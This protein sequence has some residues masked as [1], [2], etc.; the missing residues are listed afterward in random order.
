[1]FDDALVESRKTHSL[2]GTRRSLPASVAL[3][4]AV[5]GAFVGASA[6]FPGE[7]PEPTER[8]VLPVVILP[9]PASSSRDTGGG[10]K[11]ET[12]HGPGPRR[13][14]EITQQDLSN[15]EPVATTASASPSDETPT[16]DVTENG[17]PGSGT[18]DEVGEHGGGGK[19]G[20]GGNGEDILT[21]G[22]D[23]RA[24]VLLDRVEPAYPESARRAHLE[25]IVILEA[26]ITAS[27]EVRQVR[28]LKSVNPL[29][30]EAAV[31]AVGAWRYRPATLN[32][33]AVAVYLTVTV[34]FGIDG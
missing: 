20:P 18:G 33:R 16:V 12:A 17:G 34:K 15:I 6:W 3:H 2:G 7:P 19:D 24:P 4:L 30:D 5:I 1:M 10:E 32:G 28:V 21:P 8:A 23:V 11:P 27:G 22:G 29:L 25:G 14:H 31:R 26:T 9:P 13:H